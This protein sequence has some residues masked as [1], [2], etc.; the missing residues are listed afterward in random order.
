MT[1]HPGE[2]MLFIF[3]GPNPGD[4][5]G[6]CIILGVSLVCLITGSSMEPVMLG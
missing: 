4:G 3:T 6:C 1:T 5:D 2:Y